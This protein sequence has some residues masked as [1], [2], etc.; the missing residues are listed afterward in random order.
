VAPHGHS[1]SPPRRALHPPLV[2]APIGAVMIAALCDL[3]S[4]AG[5]VD[6]RPATRAVR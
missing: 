2:H 4:I 1:D 6:K 3:V 5:P